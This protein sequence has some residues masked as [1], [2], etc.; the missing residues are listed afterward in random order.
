MKFKEAELW[1][2]G[3]IRTPDL[4]RAKSLDI[5]NAT[6]SSLEIPSQT[7]GLSTDVVQDTC[8]NDFWEI[9]RIAFHEWLNLRDISKQT[10]QGYRS[11]LR[12]FLRT[13]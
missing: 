5:E 9:H 4:C 1:W 10:K 12:N 13:M 2:A 11:A 7:L 8:L 6:I 3:E